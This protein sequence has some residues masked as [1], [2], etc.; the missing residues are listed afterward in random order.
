[1]MSRTEDTRAEEIRRRRADLKREYGVAY[2]RLSEIFFDED[3]I[4]I[5]FRE[6]TDEYEPEVGS[7]VPRLRECRSQ[8]DVRR[9]VHEDFVRW[10]DV[11]TAGPAAKYAT[12][13]NRIWEE[14]LPGLWR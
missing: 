3:P 4:G 7:I 2:Q 11:V 5:N 14:V 10:F 8:E 6:N 12:I 13:A 1:M 9:I